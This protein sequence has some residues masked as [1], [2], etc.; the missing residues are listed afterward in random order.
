MEWFETYE[1]TARREVLEE[2][3][4]EIQNFRFITATNDIFQD[5]E[6]HYITIITAANWIEGE[7]KN[8][9]PHKL[10][11]WRW[12]KWGNQM[13]DN[14]FIPTANFMKLGIDPREKLNLC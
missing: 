7:P 2:A 4:L 10:V 5:E 3:D 11:E 14:L 8:M 6:K 1:D 13:P 12:F 9:E